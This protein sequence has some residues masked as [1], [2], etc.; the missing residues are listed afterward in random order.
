MGRGHS[1]LLRPHPT[2]LLGRGTY[3]IIIIIIIIIEI[4]FILFIY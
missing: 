1:P 3:I 2:G 4:K